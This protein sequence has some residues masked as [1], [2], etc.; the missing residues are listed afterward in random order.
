[1]TLLF[2]RLIS[3]NREI[4]FRPELTKHDTLNALSFAR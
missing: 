1:L 3:Q 2:R 4:K